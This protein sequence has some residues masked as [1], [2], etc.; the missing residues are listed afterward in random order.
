[1]YLRF[2]RE[3]A[4]LIGLALAL[5]ALAIAADAD[6]LL[7]G[8]TVFVG[9]FLVGLPL[10]NMKWRWRLLTRRQRI[11]E[12]ASN[13][14]VW[15]WVGYAIVIAIEKDEHDT[16]ENYGLLGG[17]LVLASLFLLFVHF[18]PQAAKRRKDCPECCNTVHVD[19]RVCQYCGYRWK[20]PLPER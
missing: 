17:M 19:A 8:L 20:P 14:F 4:P 12:V 18:I 13:A 9:I 7:V 10:G 2:F 5:V 15:I 1:M 3:N 6:D 11:W 16:W